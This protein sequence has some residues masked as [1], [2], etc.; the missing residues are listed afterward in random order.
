[1]TADDFSRALEQAATSIPGAAAAMQAT[2]AMV[3][4]PSMP[5]PSATVWSAATVAAPVADQPGTRPMAAAAPS[6]TRVTSAV[7]QASVVPAPKAAAADRSKFVL[8]AL[9]V[10]G[11]AGAVIYQQGILSRPS[12]DTTAAKPGEA[13]TAS[14]AMA[15]QNDLPPAAPVSQ[16]PQ[17]AAEPSA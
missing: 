2:I 11:V 9:L 16:P 4:A 3:A 10:V 8:V 13:P 15:L 5:P 6:D 17:A 7:P 14:P 12:G 1:Q